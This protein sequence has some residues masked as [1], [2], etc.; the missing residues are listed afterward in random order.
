MSTEQIPP[1]QRAIWRIN[2]FCAAFGVGRTKT[3]ELI[4]RGDLEAI[5]FGGRTCITDT[6]AQALLAREQANAKNGDTQ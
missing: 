3:Y 4:N 5:K 1:I 2:D 6:S